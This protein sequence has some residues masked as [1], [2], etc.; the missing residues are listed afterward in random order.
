MTPLVLPGDPSHAR[1]V[2]RSVLTDPEFAG[3]QPSASVWAKLSSFLDS[4]FS[5]AANALHDLPSWV[6]WLVFVWM[7]V[8]LLAIFGHA[9]YTLIRI[10]GSGRTPQKRAH[11]V[12]RGELLG[13]RDLDFD[14]VYKE[15]L[16]ARDGGAFAR[17]VR[18]G[19]AAGILWLDRVSWLSFAASKTNR[20][21]V[22]E[23]RGRTSGVPIFVRM[24]DAFEEVAYG[25]R[26]ATEDVAQQL[27]TDLELLR[28]ESAQ[29]FTA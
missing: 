7:T 3:A 21:Y 9:V 25:A 16:A 8:T 20:D 10:G 17:A 11:G 5:Q 27:L 29:R 28:H 15:A 4:L 14:S 2:V 26:V 24:T 1:A 18:Y 19:Y 13:I 6:T 22:A 23:L 12:P